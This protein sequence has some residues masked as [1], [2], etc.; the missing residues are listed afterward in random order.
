LSTVTAEQQPPTST[1]STVAP[2]PAQALAAVGGPQDPTLAWAEIPP[3]AP[4]LCWLSIVIKALGASLIMTAFCTLGIVLILFRAN[5]DWV[6]TRPMR[7]WCIVEMWWLGLTVRFENE[8]KVPVGRPFILVANHQSLLEGFAYGQFFRQ[9]TIY[10]I[11]R[12]FAHIPFLGRFLKQARQ[13]FIDRRNREAAIRELSRGAELLASGY[14]TVIFPEGTRRPHGTLGPFKKGPFHMAIQSKV[15]VIPVANLN[16][17]SLLPPKSLAY[18]PGVMRLVVGDPI[19]T[20]LWKEETIDEHV[21]E[22]RRAIAGP[23]SE[24]RQSLGY[25]GL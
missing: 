7:W 10:I 19:D 4:R 18:R 9:P 21:A 15:P 24:Y 22:V 5:P 14:C 17:G 16:A 6:L 8:E 12:E 20:T 11:K 2:T 23:L 13:L 25:P 1:P 3:S